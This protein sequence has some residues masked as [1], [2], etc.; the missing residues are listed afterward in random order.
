MK[1][2]QIVELPPEAIKLLGRTI[3][4]HHLLDADRSGLAAVLHRANHVRDHHAADG[5]RSGLDSLPII[6][7]AP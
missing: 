5:R 6:R 7:H 3:D 1:R 4:R 2:G